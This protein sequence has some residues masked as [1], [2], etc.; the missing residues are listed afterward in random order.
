MEHADGLYEKSTHEKW[1]RG[2]VDEPDSEK[3][4]K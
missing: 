1:R 2:P 4:L 3:P